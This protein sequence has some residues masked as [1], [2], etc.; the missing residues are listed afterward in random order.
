[1]LYEANVYQMQVEDHIF[2][3]ADSKVLKGCTGQGDTSE[4]AIKELE[5]NEC[6][7]LITAKE[8]GIPIP[9]IQIKKERTYSGK[10]ALRIS[11]YVH[12]KATE[13]ASELGISLNQFINDALVDYINKVLASTRTTLK[14]NTE[15]T[16]KIVPFPVFNNSPYN[17]VKEELEEM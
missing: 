2:W 14:Y 10:V 6:E 16:T 9:E 7:W 11:P 13:T 12:E 8:F 3:V 1:M 4:A 5:E 17:S 15:T